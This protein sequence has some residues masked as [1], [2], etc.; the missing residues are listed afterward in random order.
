MVPGPCAGRGR[1][2]RHVCEALQEHLGIGSYKTAWYM[3]HRIRK[4]MENKGSADLTGI[5]E[6][7]ETYLGGKLKGQGQAWRYNQKGQKQVVVGIKDAE[8]GSR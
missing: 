7:D 4:A 5:V 8:A 6:M 3:A 1:Q 2:E